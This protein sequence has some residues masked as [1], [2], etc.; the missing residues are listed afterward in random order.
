[1]VSAPLSTETPPPSPAPVAAL[2]QGRDPADGV[3][4]ELLIGGMES[5]VVQLPGGGQSPVS[6][7]PRGHGVVQQVRVHGATIVLATQFDEEIVPP[8]R[9]YRVADGTTTARPVRARGESIGAGAT[10]R[11]FWVFS[12]ST[13]PRA[14]TVAEHRDHDG[15]LRRRVE[16]PAGW[17]WLRGVTGGLL[18][19]AVNA[20]DGPERMMVWDPERRRAVLS[21]ELGAWPAAVSGTH[22]AWSDRS[23]NTA[24]E[25]C[26]LHVTDLRDATEQVVPLPRGHSDPYG[27]FAPVGAALVLQMSSLADPRVL[28]VFVVGLETTRVT[29]LDW[30]GLHD[31]LGV[32]LVW[33]PNGDGVVLAAL[34]YTGTQIAVWNRA[35]GRLELMPGESIRDAVSVTTRPSG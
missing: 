9:V 6:G 10:D 1:M 3:R 20:G 16:L 7:I 12:R 27:E 8:G 32:R 30:D 13:G 28:R 19:T 29:P 4:V 2:G 33:D 15:R 17:S 5:V 22:V 23:C 35:T 18:G 34:G 14:A 26:I 11:T 24:S 31:A 25:G 21:E